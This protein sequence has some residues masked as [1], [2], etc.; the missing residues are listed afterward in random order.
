MNRS[1]TKEFRLEKG[2]RQGDPLSPYLFIIASDGLNRLVKKALETRFFKGI[3]IGQKNLMVS[4]PQF[5]DDS[6]FFEEWSN[7]NALNLMKLLKC[8]E[9][10]S[11]L[12]VNLLKSNLY[13]IGVAPDDLVEMA[14][15]L[16]CSTGT[17]PFTYLGLPVSCNMKKRKDWDFVIEKVKK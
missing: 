8:F 2:V 7:T 6:I 1:P 9:K 17:I 3:E 10:A 13:G 14:S 4:H 5:A 15:N 11:G 12:K 16:R